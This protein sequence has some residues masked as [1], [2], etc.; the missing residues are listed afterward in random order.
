MTLAANADLQRIKTRLLDGMEDFMQTSE[1]DDRTP[2][3][4]PDDIERCAAI[5]DAYLAR[6][7]SSEG[8]AER[9]MSA[10]RDTVLSLNELS[11]MVE[12]L[13]ETGQRE[14]ICEFMQ[15]AATESGLDVDGGE[16]IT[17]TWREW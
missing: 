15:L 13:I 10:V 5:L 1:D 2:P 11:E 7:D 9:I 6:L 12:S 8:D 16:D 3:Y 17:E 14:D 4:A